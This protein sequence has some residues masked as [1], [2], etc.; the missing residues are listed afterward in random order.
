MRSDKLKAY[1]LRAQGRSYNEISKLLEIP[2]STLSTWFAGIELS[3]EAKERIKRRV[4]EKS[5]LSLINRNV[6]QTRQ[7]EQRAG[8]IRGLA[9]REIGKLNRRELM[10]IGT[11]LYW[12]EGYKRPIV[13]GGKMRTYHPVSLTNSDPRLI[14]VF[15]KFIRDICK[16]NDDKIEA[17]LRYF[18]HQDEAYLLNFW[19]NLTRLPS[20]R[21]KKSYSSVSISSQRKRPHNI[22]PY[23]VLQIRVSSTSLY[24]KIMGWIE[25]LGNNESA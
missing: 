16:I 23:G 15:L 10:L 1:K 13:R 14:F 21:F 25:G 20:S 6:A 7:A 12:A 2:K 5:T 22:L 4:H 24:H 18:E 3:E 19:K 17:S 11:A 8:E 9:T